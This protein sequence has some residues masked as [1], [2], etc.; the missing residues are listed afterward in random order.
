MTS[1]PDRRL[2]GVQGKGQTLQ[3]ANRISQK[4]TQRDM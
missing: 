2:G 1:F 3:P 4:H